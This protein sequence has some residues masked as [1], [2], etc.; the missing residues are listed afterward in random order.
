MR[1][2]KAPMLDCPGISLRQLERSDLLAWYAYLSTDEVIRNTSW[3]LKA[4][5][6]L[7]PLFEAIESTAPD[8]VRRLAIISEASGTLIGTIGF[9]TISDIN[10]SAEIA[11]D[12]TPGSWG[13]GIASTVCAAVTRWAFIEYGFVRIQGT[14]LETNA[15]SA[16]VLEKCGFHYE[17]TLRSYRMVRGTPRNFKMYSILN[18]D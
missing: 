13:Q 14:V 18:I 16:R 12:V 17:G 15:G 1:I 7:L 10:R 5:E 8:S 3:N 2:Q 11:Y 4:A 9:H 6:D